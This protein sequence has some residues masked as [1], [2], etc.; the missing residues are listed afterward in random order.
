[1]RADATDE[2]AR[3]FYLRYD[4]IPFPNERLRLFLPMAVLDRLFAG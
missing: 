3:Q 1:V 4:F 2:R